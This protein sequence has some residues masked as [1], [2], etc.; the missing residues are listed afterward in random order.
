MPRGDAIQAAG[1]LAD[2]ARAALESAGFPVQTTRLATQPLSLL[3]G[4]P[5]EQAHELWAQC[6][7]AGFD[8]LSLGPVLAD[9]PDADLSLLAR[10]RS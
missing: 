8:Y 4:D 7:D 1:Q 9:S 2:E 3:P 10:S 6:A 5:L